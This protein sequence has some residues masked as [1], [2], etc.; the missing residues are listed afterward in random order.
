MTDELNEAV[1]LNRRNMLYHMLAYAFS[2]LN[3]PE[4]CFLSG[5]D[6]RQRDRARHPRARR[7][8]CNS[9]EPLLGRV[10]RPRRA[11]LCEAKSKSSES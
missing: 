1:H 10:S 11:P 7:V 3:K 2:V 8:L 4:Y 6:P 5:R 9:N